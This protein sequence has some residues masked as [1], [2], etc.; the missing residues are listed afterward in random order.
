MPGIYIAGTGYK[1]PEKILDNDELSRTLDTSDEWIVRRTGIRR[2]HIAG[3]EESVWQLALEA[4]RRAVENA[5]KAEPEFSKDQIAA[6]ITATMTSD[7]ACPSVSCILQKELGLP[8]ELEAFDLSAACTGYVY[9]L[10]TAYGILKEQQQEKQK[11]PYALVVG[12]E[13]MSRIMDYSERSVC[14]LFGDGA[15]AAVIGLDLSEKACFSFLAG[16][17]G[18]TESLYCRFGE[19]GDGFMHMNGPEVYRFATT[20]LRKSIDTLLAR[21]GLTMDSV[22]WIICHQANA[23]IIESVRKNYPGHEEKFFMDMDEYANTSGASVAIALADMYERKL[24]RTGM[25]V[26][27][28]AFGAGLSWNAMLLTI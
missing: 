8:E 10:H 22:D 14:V 9:A 7:Y 26:I 25:K 27:M 11:E 17:S 6:V 18:N 24:L 15:G 28:A 5:R 12:S 3:K 1:V 4:S 16:T 23:R 2:R 19:E 13:C 21:N 20:S